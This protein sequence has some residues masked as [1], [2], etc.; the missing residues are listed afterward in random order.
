W[1]LAGQSGSWIK[2]GPEADW[3]YSLPPVGGGLASHIRWPV[4]FWHLRSTLHLSISHQLFD[5]ILV[6]TVVAADLENRDLTPANQ[7]VERVP[8]NPQILRYFGNR[9]DRAGR[10]IV[11]GLHS[12]TF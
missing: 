11:A 9:H 3:I 1:T 10:G 12:Y 8:I 6:K 5:F 4:L 2:W 7:F